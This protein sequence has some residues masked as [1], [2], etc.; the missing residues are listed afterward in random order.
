VGALAQNGDSL[1]ADQAGA[2]NDDD[3]MV[4]PHF[5]LSATGD[6]AS[7]VS[8][9][10][11]KWGRRYGLSSLSGRRRGGRWWAAAP[12]SVFTSALAGALCE[13]T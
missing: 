4:Y 3:F 6:P 11:R 10:R 7:L 2:A 13:A 12:V 9:V 1:R 5:P 8:T